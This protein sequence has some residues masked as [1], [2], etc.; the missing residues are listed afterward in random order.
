MFTQLL[1][2]GHKTTRVAK[3]SVVL[4]SGKTYG[5]LN[6]INKIAVYPITWWKHIWYTMAQKMI[7]FKI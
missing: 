2:I 4:H 3:Q 6:W 5:I 1:R 7:N